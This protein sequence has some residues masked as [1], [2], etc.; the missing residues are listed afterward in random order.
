L[1]DIILISSL[2]DMG[3]VGGIVTDH[4]K[5]TLTTK[6]GA[7]IILADKPWVNQRDGLVDLPVDEYLLVVDE[8]NSLVIFTGH[9]QPQE[10]NTLM[11][12]TELVLSTVRKWGDIKLVISTG[13]YLPSV[14]GNGNEVYGVATNKKSLDMLKSHKVFPLG[15]EVNTI[16]WFNGFILGKAKEMGVDGIGIFGEINDPETPQFKSAINII[17]IIEKI[18]KIEIDTKELEKNVVEEK[19][20]PQKE[21]P[22]IG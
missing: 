9:N 3:R 18:L 22:G 16:T 10:P 17:R 19:I 20:E 8:K 4:L 11:N 12:M 21:G 2:P 1:G 5:K 6:L 13:G 14:N 7:K 15:K